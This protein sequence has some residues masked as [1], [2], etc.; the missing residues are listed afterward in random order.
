MRR[1][2]AR[3]VLTPW[4]T[5]PADQPR[6]EGTGRSRVVKTSACPW[7]MVVAVPGLRPRALLHQ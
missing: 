2:P 4:R 1:R 5:A 3:T 7:P 6:A